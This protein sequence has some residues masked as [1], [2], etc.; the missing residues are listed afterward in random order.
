MCNLGTA[1]QDR[2]SLLNTELSETR[3][4]LPNCL[5]HEWQVGLNHQLGVQPEL[6]GTYFL[7]TQF[8]PQ[9]HLRKLPELHY[10]LAAGF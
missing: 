9:R 10:S 1:G 6:L 5:T 7:G 3:N 8:L 4:L 2:M